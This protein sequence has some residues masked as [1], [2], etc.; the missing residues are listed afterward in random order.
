MPLVR[1]ASLT[2]PQPVQYISSTILVLPSPDPSLNPIPV[3][4]ESIK[5][6]GKG[7]LDPS[8]G[9]PKSDPS[10]WQI[11]NEKQVG[12]NDRQ[13]SF[14]EFSQKCR[15]F[16]L[17][18]INQ[19][20]FDSCDKAQCSLIGGA[21]QTKQR[22]ERFAQ[23][24]TPS[25]PNNQ[26]KSHVPHLASHDPVSSGLNGT[27]LATQ[28]RRGHRCFSLDPYLFPIFFRL[29][30]GGAAHNP[31]KRV[32]VPGRGTDPPTVSGTM[33]TPSSTCPN[34]RRTLARKHRDSATEKSYEQC[35]PETGQDP[36]N[37]GS[38]MIRSTLASGVCPTSPFS[39]P[40]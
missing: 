20:L 26:T 7:V 39:G 12:K 17:D 3:Q 18:P 2:I 25:N 8:S 36:G 35:S 22:A 33:S 32:Q 29:C 11:F 10:A 23:N 30:D 38:T 9:G 4:I 28:E 40:F 1:P 31:E 15:P 21:S 16:W 13:K 5:F 24:S 37:P 27:R 6:R 14:P 19:F 34:Q